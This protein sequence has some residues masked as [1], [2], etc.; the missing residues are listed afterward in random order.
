[1]RPLLLI[2]ILGWAL[3]LQ[4]QQRGVPVYTDYLTDNL[5]LLFPSMAGAAQHSK[6]R[7]TG[8]EQWSGVKDA[9]SLQTLTI[10]GR[11]KGSQV[12]LGAILFNDRNGYFS[13]QGAYATFAYH[14]LFSRDEIV[15]NQLSFGLSV[16][17]LQEKVDESEFSGYDPVLVGG[18]NKQTY[19]NVDFGLSYYYVNF[20]AHLA[21]KN[22]IPEKS[23]LFSSDLQ[24]DNQRQYLFLTGFTL[25][26]RTEKWLFVPSVLLQYREATNEALGDLNG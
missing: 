8:R 5:Y 6:V 13:H 12:G 2:F 26:S 24:L 15:L 4:A 3:S 7:L 19:F 16:G 1:K 25:A 9:P 23:D 17:V 14:L 22:I 11:L 20:F 10:N 21:V 18:K